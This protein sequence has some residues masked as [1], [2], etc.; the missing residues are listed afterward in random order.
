MPKTVPAM[1]PT[2]LLPNEFARAV[3]S[4]VE[5][6]TEPV[7]VR[8]GLSDLVTADGHRL[9]GSFMCGARP[10]ADGA[11]KKL[12]AE[13]F[14]ARKAVATVDDLNGHFAPALHTAATSAAVTRN[15]AEWL[16]AEARASLAE[17]LRKAADRVAFA[18]GVEMLPPFE[19]ELESPSFQQQKLEAMERNLAEQ[20]VAGQVEHFEKAAAL[21]KQFDAL[22]QAAPGISPGAA[23]QQ[24]SPSEQGAMLQTLLLAGGRS[25]V[26]Q[27]IWAVAGPYLVRIDPR[28]S[29]MTTELITLPATLGPLRSVERG[30]IDGREVL[31]IGARSGVM[32]VNPENPGDVQIYQD[33]EI[34]SQL[35]FSRSVVWRSGIWACH[36]D[37]GIVGWEM[38][39]F[40]QPRTVLRPA[41]L[42]P[43]A[44]TTAAAAGASMAASVEMSRPGSPRN[45]TAVDRERLVFS[46]G[47][48]L[49]AVDGDGKVRV[50]GGDFGADIVAIVPDR[51]GVVLVRE[52]G[53]VATHDR[54]TLAVQGEERRGGKINGAAPLPWLGNQRLLLATEDGPIQCI[55]TEDPLVTQYC[56]AHRGLKRL[57]AAADWVVAVSTDRQRLVLW[58][59]WE[60]RKPAAEVGIASIARHRV[61][62]VSMG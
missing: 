40:D 23:L 60:G 33:A 62:D 37:G 50:V 42:S 8:W 1:M 3:G 30:E 59:S 47:P 16:T 14:L 12:L 22:R 29:P 19:V 9:R 49:M 26:T 11:E 13:V 36:G 44:A 20:R 6:R 57:A 10:L 55:G 25:S 48:R 58:N 21:L 38:G 4:A 18:C 43:G 34:A 24:I 27:S 56:S 41:H 32:V 61:A 7:R 17:A 31:L 28:V 46:I 51:R 5:V 45:L 39:N 15:V 54:E 35:G 53:A 52:N 2:A